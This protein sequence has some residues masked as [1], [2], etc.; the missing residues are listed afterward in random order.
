MRFE[1]PFSAE[2][3]FVVRIAFYLRV[4]LPNRQEY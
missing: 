2:A 4:H 1:E 3:I